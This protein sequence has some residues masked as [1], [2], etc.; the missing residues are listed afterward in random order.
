MMNFKKNIYTFH[1]NYDCNIDENHN[2]YLDENIKIFSIYRT[3]LKTISNKIVNC[4]N[5]EKIFLP[6]NELISL[7]ENIGNLYNLDEIVLQHNKIRFLPDSISLCNKLKFFS[8]WDNKLE[9]LPND[10]GLLENL[11]T[12]ELSNNKLSLLP[13]SF[14]NLKKL[15]SL[16]ISDNNFSIFPQHITN[17]LFLEKLDLS[18]N[19]ITSVPNEICNCINLNQLYLSHNKITSLP[20]NIGYLNLHRFHANGNLINRLPSSL[21]NLAECDMYFGD[22]PI[23]YVPP[24]VRRILER[25]KNIKNIYNDSQNVHNHEIQKSIIESINNILNDDLKCNKSIIMDNFI[26]NQNVDQQ[27]KNIIFEFCDDNTVHTVLNITFFEIFI[28]VWNR[29]IHNK[30]QNDLIHILKDEM[31]NSECK[32]FT[33][34]ISR[35]INVLNGFYDDINISISNNEQIG[36]IISNLILQYKDLNNDELKNI[37]EKELLERGY[38]IETINQWIQHID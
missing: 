19:S 33:G 2:V 3:N 5:I 31:I 24:N 38:D 34:R 17:L 13:N 26:N 4:T 7:P 16:N 1:D 23:E 20:N 9:I 29:I 10:F 35:L 25:Q 32:C 11:I 22:N 28:Y 21:G 37:I 6:E 18:A 15:T 36:S 14:D 30:S 8:A 12:L 27:T